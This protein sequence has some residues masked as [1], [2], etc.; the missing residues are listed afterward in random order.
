MDAKH[1]PFH[2]TRSVEILAAGRGD[3]IGWIELATR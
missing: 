3:W 2:V 1:P